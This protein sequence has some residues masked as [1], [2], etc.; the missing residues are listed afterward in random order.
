[1]PSAA[2]STVPSVK[3]IFWV[4]LAVLKQYQGSPLAQARQLPH[5]ARQLSTT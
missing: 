3:V 1:M 5:T 2:D 4:A